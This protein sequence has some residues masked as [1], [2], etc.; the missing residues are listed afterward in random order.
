MII[1]RIIIISP[2]NQSRPVDS[3]VAGTTLGDVVAFIVIEVISTIAAHGAV[4]TG[5]AVDGVV[6]R[7]TQ[8]GVTAVVAFQSV[9]AIAAVEGVVALAAVN[10]VRS[11]IA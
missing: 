7:L 5:G 11:G 4:V 1:Q 9:D 2:F 10:G 6:A 8:Q 3:V